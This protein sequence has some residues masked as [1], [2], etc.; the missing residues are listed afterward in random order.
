MKALLL[1][2]EYPPY[3]YGG[4]GFTSVDLWHPELRAVLVHPWHGLLSYHPLYGV[5]FAAVVNS[6]VNNLVMPIIAMIFGKPDFSD[7][8]FTINDAV[9]RYGA[10][11]TDL[12]SFVAI[13]AAVFFFVVKPLNMLAERRKRGESPEEDTPAPSDEAVLLAEIRDLLRQRAS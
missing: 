1:T 8:T 2:N 6:L 10:F 3:V 11:I 4:A 12:I 13:A 5:A 9:F 7:L